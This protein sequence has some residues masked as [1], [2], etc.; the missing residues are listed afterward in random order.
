MYTIFYSR[1]RRIEYAR[2]YNRE[3]FKYYYY[4]VTFALF[5]VQV[6]IIII[7]KPTYRGGKKGFKSA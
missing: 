6:N 4:Y 3:N 5:A 1:R 7:K 2:G